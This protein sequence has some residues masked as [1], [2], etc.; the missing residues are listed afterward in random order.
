MDI[1]MINA[2]SARSVGK[3][4]FIHL[5]LELSKWVAQI[6]LDKMEEYNAS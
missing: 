6:E 1:Y 3:H 4:F 2:D 5:N